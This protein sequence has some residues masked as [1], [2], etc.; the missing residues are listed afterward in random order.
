MGTVST[1]CM[2][3]HI[4][5][6]VCFPEW[7]LFQFRKFFLILEILLLILSDKLDSYTVCKIIY[8]F[9]FGCNGSLVL[10]T[11]FFQSQ[12]AGAIPQLWC[13]G[14]SS[15][16]TDAQLPEACGIFPEQGLNPC[17]LHWQ[18]DTLTAG[19][20][21]KSSIPIF[22][23][24]L[25]FSRLVVSHSLPPQAHKASLPFTI[26]QNLPKLMCIELV[27]AS[28]YLVL[29]HPLLLLPSIFPNIRIFSNESA[30]CIR[31]PKFWSFT[32]SNSPS[33]EYS[34]LISFRI[35]WFDLLAVLRNSQIFS[36]TYSY[37]IFLQGYL[38]SSI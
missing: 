33:S 6:V 37:N 23:Q 7:F 26:S 9:I 1:G 28:K 30:V 3:G 35:D 38:S 20:P 5:E 25:L 27:M 21:G 2:L 10:C 18:A 32:C 16:G 11:G 36:N 29:C 22:Q 15:C 31:W 13:E 17:S 19:P 14:F 4:K 12:Q 8:L 34:G 24:L